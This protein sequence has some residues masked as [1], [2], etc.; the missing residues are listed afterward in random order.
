MVPFLAVSNSDFHTTVPN[1]D[2][3]RRNSILL[4]EERELRLEEAE[5]VGYGF[6]LPKAD[7]APNA[8]KKIALKSDDDVARKLQKREE[9]SLVD[10]AGIEP[11]TPCLQSRCSPS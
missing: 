2:G 5:R 8:P 10:V 11:A 1:E 6:D 4:H 9:K 3:Y 7:V